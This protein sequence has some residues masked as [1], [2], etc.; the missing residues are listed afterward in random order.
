VAFRRVPA[1]FNAL[2]ESYAKA[3]YAMEAMNLQE[4]LH[5][6]LFAALHVQRIR[7]DK[8]SDMA[9]WVGSNGGDA[10]K[11]LEAAKSF[12]VATKMRQ[13]KQLAEAYKIDSVPTMGVHGRWFT[14]G[15]MAGTHQRALEVASQL[16]ERARKGA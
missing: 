12:G 9:A 8:D 6:R 13:A 5:K 3:Y 11:F 2:W 4:S 7:L 15:G 16:I 10:G 1:A 14:S